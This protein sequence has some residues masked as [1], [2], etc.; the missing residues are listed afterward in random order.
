MLACNLS[1]DAPALAR[2]E[3]AGERARLTQGL[4]SLA[5]IH[6]EGTELCKGSIEHL[7]PSGDVVAVNGAAAAPGVHATLGIVHQLWPRMQLARQCLQQRLRVAHGVVD[8]VMGVRGLPQELGTTMF[9]GPPNTWFVE[10]TRPHRTSERTG[11]V[12]EVERSR[13][14]LPR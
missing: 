2:R 3:H 8:G 7:R 6:E 13:Q 4:G 5:P 11:R 12:A 10:P 14:P 9:L 1:V